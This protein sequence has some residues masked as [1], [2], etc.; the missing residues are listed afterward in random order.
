MAIEEI[1]AKVGD[2]PKYSVN[3]DMPASLEEAVEK[4][5]SEVVFSNFRSS[6]VINLQSFM[7]SHIKADD[8]NEAALQSAVD[9]WKPG[10]KARGK[11]ATEKIGDLF[12]KLTPEERANILAR[13]LDDDES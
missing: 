4:Y 3:F 12:E 5:G 6:L 9:S 2:G 8:F 1:Q 7:R 11:S 10:T 13:F